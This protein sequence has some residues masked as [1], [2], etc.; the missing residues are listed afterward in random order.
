MCL[1]G[2]GG[3][4]PPV[5]PPSSGGTEAGAGSILGRV[6]VSPQ[7]EEAIERVSS[8]EAGLVLVLFHN[9]VF[10]VVVFDFGSI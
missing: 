7:D 10:S 1:G 4:T 5:A 6:Q 9:L 8:I 2:G 3:A